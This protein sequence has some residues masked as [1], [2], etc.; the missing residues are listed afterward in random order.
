MTDTMQVVSDLSKLEI[1]E[2]V[3]LTVIDRAKVEEFIKGYICV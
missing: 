3:T 1:N 2:D